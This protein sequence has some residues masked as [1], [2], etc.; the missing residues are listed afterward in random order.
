M[1][2]HI[3][4]VLQTEPQ[5]GCDEIVEHKQNKSRCKGVG[6]QEPLKEANPGSDPSCGQE[7]KRDDSQMHEGEPVKV[8][9]I[10][11]YDCGQDYN[12]K[13]VSIELL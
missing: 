5:R 7:R 11:L 2:D 4:Q 8:H 13:I 1:V 3:A 10:L 6:N 12:R 9:R